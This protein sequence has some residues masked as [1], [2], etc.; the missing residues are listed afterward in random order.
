MELKDFI[1]VFAD[2][3][4]ET[5]TTKFT[6]D[7]KFKELDDWSSLTVMIL[8]TTVKNKMSKN[9]T[10]DEVRSCSTIAELYHLIQSK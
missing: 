8:I 3:F 6:G 2:V 9:I 4:D 5:D 10:G 7:T 1:E